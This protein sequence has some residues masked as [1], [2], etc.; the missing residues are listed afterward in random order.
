M[1]NFHSGTLTL[2]NTKNLQ[3]KWTNNTKYTVHL[4]INL[5]VKSTQPAAKNKHSKAKASY[6]PPR[7]MLTI[8]AS[9]KPGIIFLSK[10]SLYISIMRYG[11]RGLTI[12]HQSTNSRTMHSKGTCP[13]IKCNV[14]CQN[15]TY[16]NLQTVYRTH[17]QAR[18]TGLANLPTQLALIH[19]KL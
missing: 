8:L 6:A 5:C 10:R 16:S 1:C 18:F 15:T 14:Y 12:P 19:P 11:S 17:S 2:N 4:V 9:T 3:F 13:E 7:L